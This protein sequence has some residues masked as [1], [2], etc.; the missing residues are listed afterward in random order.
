MTI[1]EIYI[2][3]FGKL[4]DFRL[5]PTENLNIIYGE[6]ETGK[7][8][9]LAFIRQM[10]YGGKDRKRFLPRDGSACSGTLTFHYAGRQYFLERTFG[11]SRKTDVINLKNA[12]TGAVIPIPL[13]QEPGEWLFDMMEDTFLHTV[14]IGQLACVFDG[15]KMASGVVTKLSNLN[16]AGDEELSY[17][18]TDERLKRA[19]NALSFR[20]K[21]RIPE[22][23]QRLIQLE[24]EKR[25]LNISGEI[26]HKKNLQLIQMKKEKDTAEARRKN[27]ENYIRLCNGKMELQEFEQLEE[28]QKQI[29]LHEQEHGDIADEHDVLSQA[30]A[31]Y[32]ECE[33][34]DAVIAS[35]ESD[36][37]EQDARYRSFLKEYEDVNAAADIDFDRVNQ[38]L[39]YL[40]TP[41][42]SN[43]GVPLWVTAGLITSLVLT[44]LFV[45]LSVY[46]FWMLVGAIAAS[47]AALGFAVMYHRTNGTQ[48]PVDEQMLDAADAELGHILQRAG[49]ETIEDL[50]QKKTDLDAFQ[51][52]LYDFKEIRG[53]ATENLESAKNRKKVLENKLFHLLAPIAEVSTLE[54]VLAVIERM[55]G[56]NVK[57][58]EYSKEISVLKAKRDAMLKEQEY[59]EVKSRAQT[60]RAE[61][62]KV[63]NLESFQ[64]EM[65][66]ECKQELEELV[67]EISRITADIARLEGEIE[68]SNPGGKTVET[69]EAEL[70]ECHAQLDKYQS[71]YSAAELARSVLNTANEEMGSVFAPGINATTAKILSEITAGAYDDVRI[72]GD[73]EPVVLDKASGTLVEKDTLSGG[74]VDQLYLALRLAVSSKLFEEKE[75]L[76]LLL[77]ETLTQYDDRRMQQAID[78]LAELP[79]QILLF[80][81]QKREMIAVKELENVNVIEL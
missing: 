38:L 23:E 44:A 50:F 63:R 5:T 48:K 2:K 55:D 12:Q 67:V 64:I 73:L 22:L 19:L 79:Q 14:Y 68:S 31:L 40:E 54:Q 69:I 8:T 18:K 76:P 65:L 3:N 75:P 56:S 37:S 26:L 80:S 24:E 46:Q 4:K 43:G 21:G 72:S 77:D 60:I 61:L 17:T 20:N 47:V 52:R 27:C 57:N 66:P 29:L 11:A 1:V 6:N 41:G 10:L 51:L 32:R 13:K 16:T 34:T 42:G 39:D 15:P 71:F 33:K 53:I 81:C 59:E 62:S 74:T 9:I 30:K 28:I 70:G 25:N 36:F 7:S 45:I 49:C 35:C 58:M 78:Y